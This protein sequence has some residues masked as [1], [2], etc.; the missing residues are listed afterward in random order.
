VF[1]L[2]SVVYPGL[3]ELLCVGT[4]LLVDRLCGRF[5]PA[6]LLPVVGAAGLVA[7]SQLT[8]YEPATAPATPFVIAAIGASGILL[9][10]RRLK[11]AALRPRSRR[12]QLWLPAIVYCLALAPVLAFGQ[13]T[14]SG[15]NVLSDSAFHMMGADYLIRHGQSYAHL[16]LHNSYGRYLSSYYGTGY[17]SGADTLFGGS[18]FVLGVPTIWAFQPFNAFMLAIAAG[19]AWLLARKVGLTGR[20]AALAGL[21]ATMAA[22]VY[23]YE[24]IGSIK[25]ITALPLIL[26]LGAL[27]VSHERW[28]PGPPRRAAP[29]A[30]T[31]AAGISVLGVGF[32]VWIV[33]SVVVLVAVAGFEVSKGRSSARRVLVLAFAA[34]AVVAVAAWPTWSSVA[35]SFRGAQSI[36]STSSPGN[37]TTP[38]KL[39]QVF[40]TWL[41]GV[42]TV[43]PQGFNA[44]LSYVVIAVTAAAALAGFNHM[45]RNRQEDVLIG[46]IVALLAVAGVLLADATTWID[47][48]TLMLSSPIVLI[49]A[50]TGVAALLQSSHARLAACLA[51]VLTAGVLGSDVMQYRVTDLAPPARYAELASIDSRFAGRGPTLF[52]DWDEYSLYE[53]RD[54]DV[55]GPDFLYPPPALANVA[56]IHS[57]PVNLDAIAPRDFLPYPLIITR[58]DPVA[59]RPPYAYRL[60]WRGAYYEVW[61]RRPHAPAALAHLGLYAS[62]SVPCARVA[63]LARTAERHHGHLVAALAPETVRVDLKRASPRGANRVGQLSLAGSASVSV[64]FRVPHTGRW[65]LWL[66]GEVM[67]VVAV[68][69]DGRR[70]AK[71]SDQ[72]DGNDF[73]PDTIGPLR[74][75]LSAGRHRLTFSPAGSILAP[76]AIGE[77]SV[78]RIFLTT[79][80]GARGERLRIAA[81][82]AWRSL[83]RGRYDWIEAVTRTRS[84][85]DGPRL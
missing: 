78:G 19:P 85:G 79:P 68:G 73:N 46:W 59:S 35:A 76:G 54:L 80:R 58:I 28:L 34:V 50:W 11:A 9:E 26:T 60:L 40:G 81:P 69:V 38:L 42:Y 4:G 17:P 22:L 84:I 8:T 21:T 45:W 30:L 61:G 71:L 77:A 2:T 39:V 72:L 64:S 33:A 10:W 23:A 52:T 51:F 41:S 14:F 13:A 47:A 57:A 32:G 53:L 62:R 49:L 24:L 1:I 15:Y 3:L 66:R 36:A 16:D 44:V 65:D 83:C 5:L 70:I 55:G 31:A 43:S 82:S 56:P 74:V 20:W 25:E 18:A 67:P 37:L 63:Q 6:V 75:R 48:K 27:V 7:I 12:W 29:F